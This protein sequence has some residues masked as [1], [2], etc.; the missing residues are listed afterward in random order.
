MPLLISFETIIKG[1]KRYMNSLFHAVQYIIL[2]TD[3]D[4]MFMV[5]S[6]WEVSFTAS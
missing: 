4:I 1:K 3:V 5:R 2:I 6:V